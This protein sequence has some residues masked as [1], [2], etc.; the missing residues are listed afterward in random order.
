MKIGFMQGRLVPTEK[1][2]SI[3]YF[4][5]TEFCSRT[6]IYDLCNFLFLDSGNFVGSNIVLDGGQIL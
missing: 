5:S 6:Q 3:Q 1:K 4:P 2:N